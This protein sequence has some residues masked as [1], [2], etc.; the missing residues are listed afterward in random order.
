[1]KKSCYSSTFASFEN[2]PIEFYLNF[3]LETT[4]LKVGGWICKLRFFC[5][6]QLIQER[7]KDKNLR[8]KRRQEWVKPLLGKKSN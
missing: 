1:M 2:I 5:G 7:I 8:V 4:N 3:V 6:V